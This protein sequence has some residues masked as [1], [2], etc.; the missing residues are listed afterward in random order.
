MQV[1]LHTFGQPVLL[2]NVSIQR[3]LI[4]IQLRLQMPMD[5]HRPIHILLHLEV[6]FQLL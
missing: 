1:H 6:A 2:L 3:A 4:H 5:V